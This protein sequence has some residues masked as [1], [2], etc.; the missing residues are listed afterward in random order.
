MLSIGQKRPEK[1]RRGD[2][3]A[4]LIYGLTGH[5]F[6]F[7]KPRFTFWF[8]KTFLTR[9]FRQSRNRALIEKNI[10]LAF[11]DK[12]EKEKQAILNGVLDALPLAA[13]ELMLQNYWRRSSLKWTRHNLDETWLEP[14]RKNE[15]QALFLLGH[16]AGWETNIMTL[17]NF[18]ENVYGV[19]APPK[20]PLLEPY[21]RE[22]RYV[23]NA[24]WT[25]LPRDMKGLQTRIS[26]EFAAGRS[27]IYIL[28]APLPGPMLPFL[29][30]HSPTTLTPY[31]VAANAGAP[32]IPLNCGRDRDR[33]GFWIEA[34]K[35]IFAE[36]TSP[37]HIEHF[38]TEMNHVYSSWI[39]A[40]PDHWY[41]TGKFFEPNAIWQARQQAKENL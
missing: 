15:K 23:K 24:S 10:N 37:S 4:A 35:P 30:L 36:G 1:L 26:R 34:Q 11:P 14:Y 27:L 32:I 39:R 12:G 21:F 9:L 41:W 13:A 3:L 22:R 33:L 17:S 2:R 7:L 16:F 8:F 6:S 25:L 19:Y 29:G 40:N 18:L 31:R 28:D 38:A 20:N 5:L